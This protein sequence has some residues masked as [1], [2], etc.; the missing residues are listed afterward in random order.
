MLDFTHLHVHSQYSILDGAASLSSLINKTKASGMKAL[1]LTD[2]GTML[3]IKEFHT[4]CKKNKIKPILGCE[5]YVARRGMHNKTEKIDQSGWHLILLAK[6]LTG[7]HN[8]IKLISKANLD[9]TYYRARIDKELLEQHSEGLIVSSACLGGEIPK[10]IINGN[11]EEAE[12]SIKWFKKLFGDDFYLEVMYHPTSDPKLREV[13]DKQIIINEKIFELAAKHNIKVIATND[14][15][16][17]NQED[18][19]AH[20]ILVCLTTNVDFDNPKRMRY[21]QQE[22]LKTP[23]EMFELFAEHSEALTNTAEIVEKIENFEIDSTP[24]MPVFPIPEEFGKLE[25][26]REKF[27]ETELIKEFGETRFNELGGYEP[28]LKIKFEGDYLKKLVEIGAIERYGEN[29]SETIKERI[30]F[31][32]T[33]IKTMGFPG[34]FLIVQDF[35]AEARKMGV[36]VGKGR[37]SAAGSVVAYCTK[38]TDV[39]PIAFDLLF[40]R[41]LNPDRISMPDVDIDFDDD[42]REEVINYVK[43]KYGK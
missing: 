34:Y 22:W 36:F 39:D 37:G 8:L 9:G 27:S 28:V 38:I 7:Y 42:G 20:D 12:N 18:A 3:G 43:N 35:I 24:I 33:T 19:E 23:E 14:V 5:T 1:A 41:F 26:W 30:D 11:I 15:H 25:K 6:N 10:H 32:L 40:E 31:E 21:T 4:L 2:H 17:T 29:L 16:F 13:P